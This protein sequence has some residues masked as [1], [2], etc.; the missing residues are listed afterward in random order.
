MSAALID[1]R[2]S[3]GAYQVHVGHGLARQLSHELEAARIDGR[4]TLVSS[5]R[6]W[7]AQGRHVRIGGHRATP[8]LV[9]DGERAK[10]LATVAR[11]YDGLTRAGVDRGSVI[12]AVGGGVVGDMV[13]FAAATYLRGVALVHVPTTL[14]AQVDSAIGGKVGVNTARGKNLVGA[15]HPPRRVIV[16]PDL[17]ATLP[18]REFRA[19]LYE[20][21]KY[22]VIA[23]EPLLAQLDAHLDQVLRQRGEVLETVVAECCRI[24][25]AIVTADERESGIR[26]TLNFGHTI[27]HALEAVSGYR[28][29]RH[30]EAVGLGMKA[31]LALGAARGVTPRGTAD[32]VTALIDRLGR[33]PRI[34]DLDAR[35]VVNAV[36]RDKK[37]VHGRLHFIA[38]TAVGDTTTLTDVSAA[39]LRQ[40]VMAL[41][42]R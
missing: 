21:I 2:A 6:V 19:G 14:M 7:S 26:R 31:A 8:L 16:D 33:L 22:G 42:L 28:R 23:S 41:G 10:Q 13:G 11:L 4:P 25:G 35:A 12:V 24:K 18:P 9:P 27:G 32:R 20:V 38:A 30:G 40:A 34:D 37:V 1:V 36:S 29:L 39:E 3:D 17:L 15:F 5:R